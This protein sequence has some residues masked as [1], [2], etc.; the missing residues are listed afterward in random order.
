MVGIV[1]AMKLISLRRK[2]MESEPPQLYDKVDP[3]K[4]IQRLKELLIYL[5]K[6]KQEGRI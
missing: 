1:G 5:Q 4:I 6:M 2:R 3:E